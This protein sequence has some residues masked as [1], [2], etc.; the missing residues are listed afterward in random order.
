MKQT[1]LR[2][3]RVIRY[4]ILYF[5]LL[6]IFLCLIVGPIVAG[7]FLKL[8]I[9]NSIPMQIMQPTGYNNNDT[10]AIVTGSCIQDKCPEYQ[11]GVTG[12]GGDSTEP[13]ATTDAAAR[14][15]RYMAY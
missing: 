3:R 5:F 12:G 8:D 7:K 6:I 10:N 14:F 1:K 11:G 13:A 9:G 2:K 4:A 15:R